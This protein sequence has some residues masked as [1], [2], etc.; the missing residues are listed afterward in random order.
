MSRLILMLCFLRKKKYILPMF[1][2]IT[3]IVKKQVAYL[4]IPSG[5]EWRYLAL[6]R[7]T[8]S[9]IIVDFIV[10][11]VFILLEKNK[12]QS[13]KKVRENKDFCNIKI[14]SEDTKILEFNQYKKSDKGPLIIYAD[15]ECLIEKIDWC[16]NNPENSST[17]KVRDRIPSGFWMSTILSFKGIENK[18]DVCR[19]KD[20]MRKFCESLREHVMK[21]IN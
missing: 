8:T 9:K 4:M 17:T 20:C 16:K 13:H 21:I 1:Q 5:E 6:L 3:Q 10:W 2:D 7:E 14:V 15:L 18:H 11:I 19:G 12:L